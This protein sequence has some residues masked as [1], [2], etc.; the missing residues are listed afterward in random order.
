MILVLTELFNHYK[1]PYPKHAPFTEYNGLDINEDL[2]NNICFQINIYNKYH[3]Q[4]KKFRELY[5]TI[6][7]SGYKTLIMDA[8]IFR[9]S[10]EV[11]FKVGWNSFLFNESHFYKIKNCPGDRWKNLN[12]SIKPWQSKIGDY[13][14]I[15]LQSST[16]SSLVR[17]HD[18]YKTQY[19]WLN[20][21]LYKLRTFTD[22]PIV[23]RDHPDQK[24][25]YFGGNIKTLLSAYKNITLMPANK[26]VKNNIVHGGKSLETLLEKAHACISWTST[27]LVEATCSGVP[28]YPM[29]PGAI[30]YPIGFTD[31]SKISKLHPEPYK[32]N[33][34]FY[35]TAYMQWNTKEVENGIMW[36]FIK[37]YEN[38]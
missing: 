32:Y 36:N 31:L 9:Q 1:A 8:A 25:S 2:L 3:P 37:R 20:L 23:I 16:D 4:K 10:S 14:V 12:I 34:W 13:I 27:A 30:T 11:Y 19:N 22:M 18:A 15:F 28:V 17:L 24:H 29:S 35:N 33:E 26:E 7:L 21:L 5:K 6:E 38:I